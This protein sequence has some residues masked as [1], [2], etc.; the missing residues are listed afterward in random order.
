MDDDGNEDGM[1][2][3]YVS[4]DDANGGLNCCDDL[5]KQVNDGYS[6]DDC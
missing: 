5:Q 4:H 6:G 2:R 3:M 1:R